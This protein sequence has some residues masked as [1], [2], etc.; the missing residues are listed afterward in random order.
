MKTGTERLSQGQSEVEVLWSRDFPN[1]R[2]TRSGKGFIEGEK[3][4]ENLIDIVSVED[5]YPLIQRV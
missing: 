1:P 4:G 5:R 3:K 2:E